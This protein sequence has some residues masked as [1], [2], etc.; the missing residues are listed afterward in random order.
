MVSDAGRDRLFEPQV[1]LGK[2]AWCAW[3]ATGVSL[4]D[5][6][7]I[8]RLEVIEVLKPIVLEVFFDLDRTGDWKLP[9]LVATTSVEMT[10][11]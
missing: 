3:G 11:L 8:E 2:P 10:A 4:T 6:D 7:Q 1:D 9:F 5:A